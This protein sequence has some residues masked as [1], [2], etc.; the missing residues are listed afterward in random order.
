M[1]CPWEDIL[2][3]FINSNWYVS[4]AHKLV[5]EILTPDPQDSGVPS[6]TQHPRFPEGSTAHSSPV[7]SSQDSYQSA[8]DALPPIS[9]TSCLSQLVR[10]TKA[11]FFNSFPLTNH[12]S[13]RAHA[14]SQ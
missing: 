6:A 2:E 8:R 13:G 5:Q 1:V 3:V 12:A 9:V 11:P 7:A 10:S 14:K 4:R